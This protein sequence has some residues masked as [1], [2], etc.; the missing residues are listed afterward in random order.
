MAIKQFISLA[1]LTEYDQLLKNYVAAEDAKSIKSAVIDGWNLKLYTQEAPTSQDVPKYN[2]TLPQQDLSNFVEKVIEGSNGRAL[3]WNEGDG[4]CLKF[5]HK[6]GT[7][8]AVAVNDGGAGGLAAQ[9]YAVNKDT[10]IG[11]RLNVSTTGIYYTNGANSYAWSAEN[12]LATKADIK[13]DANTKT[14]YATET[15]GGSSDPYA[16]KYSFY[17]GANGSAQSPVEAEKVIDLYV[18]KDMVISEGTVTDVTYSN[19]HLYDGATDVTEIIKGSDP[20]TVAD[21]GKYIRL[22]VANATNDR[23]YIK[24]SDLVDVYTGGTNAE[25]SVNIDANNEI[26]VSL[27]ASS[28]AKSKL[29]ASVQTALDAGSTALQPNDVEPVDSADIEALFS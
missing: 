22:T 14:V 19:G 6:D 16:K 11:S 7:Y 24:A 13:G 12:E 17:Q 29:D 26:T 8:S 15:P 18:P 9:L 27:V 20:A 5:E 2:I 3:V 4:G 28:I 1:N 21:A 23:I 10:K 25:T